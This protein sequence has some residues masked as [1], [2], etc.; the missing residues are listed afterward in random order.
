MDLASTSA[1]SPTG[2]AS[3]TAASSTG[4]LRTT[5]IRE[6]WGKPKAEPYTSGGL[7]RHRRHLE[8]AHRARAAHRAGRLR[9][10]QRH[11]DLR[12]RGRRRT[13]R[14][15]LQRLGRPLLL[16][17]AAHGEAPP[18]SCASGRSSRSRSRALAVR[19]E[20]RPSRVDFR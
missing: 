18:P 3:A 1:S 8:N 17:P 16:L 20:D 11:Q 2:F 13:V 5:T 4:R 12:D 10:P 15:G 6:Q 14:P 9:D 7:A 19:H